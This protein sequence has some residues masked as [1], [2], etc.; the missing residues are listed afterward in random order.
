MIAALLGGLLLVTGCGQNCGS[1][2]EG[3][4]LLLAEGVS[5]IAAPV[6]VP[7]VQI[8][9]A[10]A[11]GPMPK[12]SEAVPGTISL[13]S[14]FDSDLADTRATWVNPGQFVLW[15]R[16]KNGAWISRLIM[17]SG[18]PDPSG[19]EDQSGS[20]L[21]VI[22][23]R[24]LFGDTTDSLHLLDLKTH[25][26]QPVPY[27]GCS[28]NI[29]FGNNSLSL[30][31]RYLACQKLSSP[32]ERI[33]LLIDTATWRQTRRL[34]LRGLLDKDPQTAMAFDA[35]DDLLVG[36]SKGTLT[37]YPVSAEGVEIPLGLKGNRVLSVQG[38]PGSTSAV[39]A[40]GPEPFGNV[41]KSDGGEAMVFDVLTGAKHFLVAIT[42][43]VGSV[44]FSASSDG[45]I[46]AIL[47]QHQVEVYDLLS[48]KRVAL[49]TTGEEHRMSSTSI[50][51]TGKWLIVTV[52]NKVALFQLSP[53]ENVN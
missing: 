28:V 21:G 39:A 2:G 36:S 40:V 27:L 8:E 50:D 51:P 34:T 46:L 15:G 9:R 16:A 5:V 1:C 6:V 44:Q 7:A 42:P 4:G 12:V 13:A 35:N 43:P 29:T 3:A 48:A 23:G 32:K 47:E 53:L 19:V 45:R 26:S 25:I 41:I 49:I 33:V 10:F 37:R 17:R 38:I 30:D 14:S 11:R 24:I 31:G 22:E 18:S 20:P 52:E